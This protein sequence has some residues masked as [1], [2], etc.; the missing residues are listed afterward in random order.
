MARPKGDS[1]GVKVRLA[2]ELVEKLEASAKQHDISYNHEIASR[3]G[4]S[5]SVENIF[6]GAEG[7]SLFQFF[8]HTF[9]AA[10]TAKSGG[11]KFGQWRKNGR[12]YDAAMRA[13]I[14]AVLNLHPHI[15]MET[16]LI[17]ESFKGRIVTQGFKIQWPKKN[18]K[19]KRAGD[20]A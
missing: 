18:P 12:A 6:G 7:E 14:D 8:G 17:A 3:L 1:V 20:A 4:K 19:Q 10:G 5:Y 13:L 9:I 2:T 11:Q 15:T 16:L